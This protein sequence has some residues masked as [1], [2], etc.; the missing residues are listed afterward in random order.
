MQSIVRGGCT[1]YRCATWTLLPEDPESLRTGRHRPLLREVGF[2]WKDCTVHESLS[3][4]T[5]LEATKCECIESTTRQHQLWSAGPRIRQDD[6][7]PKAHHARKIGREKSEGGWS[8]IDKLGEP[9]PGE[10]T[11]ARG[12]PILAQEDEG[13]GSSAA[14]RSKPREDR[15]AAAPNVG[16]WHLVVEKGAEQ[17]GEAWRCEDPRGPDPSHKQEAVASKAARTRDTTADTATATAREEHKMENG[18][19]SGPLCI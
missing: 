5:F 6:T 17:F 1:L 16:E 7:R 12:C 3:Y 4:R 10:T 11:C 14:W 8:N 13:S 19:D 2:R 18:R 9:S 15:I